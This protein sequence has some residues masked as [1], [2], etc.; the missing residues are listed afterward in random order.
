[1]L[2]HWDVYLVPYCRISSNIARA[3]RHGYLTLSRNQS[4]N[5]SSGTSTSSWNW[6]KP[7]VFSRLKLKAILTDFFDCQGVMH[8]EYLPLGHTVIYLLRSLW[9]ILCRSRIF[10]FPKLK[11]IEEFRECD[12]EVKGQPL[13]GRPRMHESQ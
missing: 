4:N 1:M 5:H 9:D 2:V 10:S 13:V 8:Y 11:L 12:G 3:T 6:K 7:N